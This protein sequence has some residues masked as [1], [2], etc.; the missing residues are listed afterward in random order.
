MFI[1]EQR[2]QATV[3][4]MNEDNSLVILFSQNVPIAFRVG[5]GESEHDAL[6]VSD[7]T[8]LNRVQKEHLRRF[9]EKFILAGMEVPLWKE[10][11]LNSLEK[12]TIRLTRCK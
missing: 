3:L 9:V 2:G 4:S 11:F 6:I 7:S 8:K 12:H 10:Q 5:T 1:L